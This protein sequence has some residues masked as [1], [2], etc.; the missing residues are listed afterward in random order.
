MPIWLI[1][2]LTTGLCTFVTAMLIRHFM[3]K[4]IFFLATRLNEERTAHEKKN[5]E[6]DKLVEASS[7]LLAAY[8]RLQKIDESRQAH[9]SSL[10]NLNAALKH[11]NTCAKNER[12]ST[13]RVV[14]NQEEMVNKLTELTK[15]QE[16][17]I[18]DRDARLRAAD[19]IVRFIGN[20]PPRTRN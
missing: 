3:N 5:A 13:D 20:T 11:A 9:I 17:M 1:T 6:Y 19:D 10:E 2:G 7:E 15:L 4:Q 8:K 14:K 12:E 16:K 18:A